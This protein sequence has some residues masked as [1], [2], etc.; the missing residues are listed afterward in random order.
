MM[1][2]DFR[3]S[4]PLPLGFE[5]LFFCVCQTFFFFSVDV[6]GGGGGDSRVVAGL[7]SIKEIGWRDFPEAT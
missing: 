1:D 2:W 4:N 5:S 7:E 6:V 3:F